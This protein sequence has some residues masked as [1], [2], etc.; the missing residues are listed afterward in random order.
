MEEQA[1][2]MQFVTLSQHRMDLRQLKLI[3][4]A[5]ER[6][7]KGEFGSYGDCGE[8]IPDKR[9]KSCHGSPLLRESF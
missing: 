2:L 1:S 7:N 9:L 3:D 6:L 4:A 8:P 5:L